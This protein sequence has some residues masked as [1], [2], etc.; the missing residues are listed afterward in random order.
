M[1][2]TLFF[3]SVLS[4]VFLLSCEKENENES[5][6]DQIINYSLS[7]KVQKGPFLAGTNIIVSELSS[8][9]EL[10]GRT[11]LGEIEDDLGY[12]QINNINLES[13]YVNLNANGFYFNEVNNSTST[14]PISLNAIADLSD[15]TT[16]N[17]N[18]LTHIEKPRVEKLIS[19]GLSFIEAKRQAQTEIFGLFNIQIEEK[20]NSELLDINKTGEANEALLAVSVLLQG[21]RSEADFTEL[22]THISTDLKDDGILDNQEYGSQLINHAI[23][24]DS[25]RICNNLRAR[26]QGLE[27]SFTNPG[28]YKYVSNFIEKTLFEITD[29]LI[30]Y[31]T[32]GT[33]GQN[34]LALD[35]TECNIGEIGHSIAVELPK[36]MSVNI[37][38]SSLTD[39]YA[40]GHHVGTEVNWLID[41]PN[42]YSDTQEGGLC[43]VKTD[44]IGPAD[45][46]ADS[47]LIEYFENSS[48]DPNI[49]KVIHIVKD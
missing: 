45:L 21:F 42:L 11:F 2:K 4:L 25:A 22:M 27:S 29:R 28:F 19:E 34:I 37:R 7:G 33:Y 17:V 13:Q 39:G 23:Y 10:T 24:L 16:L 49:S 9:L 46:I 18:V 15:Q 1:K 43:D 35:F 36:N 20:T 47:V 5:I 26:Y 12:F 32:L 8:N 3:A 44:L 31:P 41:M 6:E 30:K 40:F 38:I 14:S 48:H